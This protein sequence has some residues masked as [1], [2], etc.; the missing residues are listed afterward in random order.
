MALMCSKLMT[1][2]LSRPRRV[3][4]YDKRGSNIRR[5]RAGSPVLLMMACFPASTTSVSPL[6]SRTSHCLTPLPF[7][8]IPVDRSS[9]PLILPLSSP[10][11]SLS[12]SL[13][14]F[15]TFRL[16]FSLF[17]FLFLTFV[18]LF[19]FS[20]I[21]SSPKVSINIKVFQIYPCNFFLPIFYSLKI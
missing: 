3:E 6:P 12:L 16:P 8:R 14:F 13:Y 4:G 18:L 7:F 20:S 17:Y 19:F 1:M 2:A 21:L 5:S 10:S 9:P 15:I 11:L